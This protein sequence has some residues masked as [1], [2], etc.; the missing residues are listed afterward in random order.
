VRKWRIVAGLL[1]KD[2]IAASIGLVFS[3]L[4][5]QK[6]VSFA[7]GIIFARLL[8][9]EQYGI[10]TLGFFFILIMVSITG[11]GITASFG[12]YAPRYA[13]RG[14]LRWFFRKAYA[15]NISLG[16][17]VGVVVFLRPSVFSRLIYNEPGET[18]VIMAAALAIP[19]MVAIRNLTATFA[20]LKLFRASSL[21][22]FGQ[23]AVYALLGG[24]LVAYYRSAAV[25][26]L[27]YGVSML[28]CI[29]FFAPLLGKYLLSQEPVYR[30]PDEPGFY[31]RL[32][33]FTVWFT[34][35]PIL[36]HIFNY[37]DRLSLQRLM[38][39]SDQGIYSAAINLGA[40]VSA[41]GLAVNSV[42]YPQLSTTWEGGKHDRTLENLDISIRVTAIGLLVVGLVLVLLAKPIIVL[43]LGQDYSAGAQV[44]PWLVVFYLLSISLWLFGVYPTLV[45][46]TYVSAVGLACAVPMNVILN[47]ILIPRLGIVGAAVATVVSYMVMWVITVRICAMFGMPVSRRTVMVSLSPFLLLLPGLLAIAAVG[48]VIYICATKTWI[49]TAAERQ[50]VYQELRGFLKSRIHSLRGE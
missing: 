12:R 4:M 28:V 41:I 50:R 37:V 18:A 48:L 1:H 38:S 2:R 6:V 35:T 31:K 46:R 8:G 3:L 20:G 34:V 7:R 23:V 26:L 22:E 24:L 40:T 43:L 49:V 16:L 25:G 29:P 9:T 47:L 32:L 27:S 15:L 19:G 11:L 17:A 5:A 33:R 10:Y 36:V 39:A 45:E 42:I 14:A 30:R 44:L 13:N 21:L